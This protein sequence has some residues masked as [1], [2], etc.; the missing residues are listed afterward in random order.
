M[1]EENP[2]HR[3]CCDLGYYYDTVFDEEGTVFMAHQKT[4]CPN[5]NG[6]TLDPVL[7]Y[8]LTPVS[9]NLD[10]QDMFDLGWIDAECTHCYKTS[11][12]GRAKMM[13]AEKCPKCGVDVDF[14][15]LYSKCF[16]AADLA[17]R[18]RE[19]WSSV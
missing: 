12:F 15:H 14:W 2:Y 11:R 7:R 16:N 5:C 10:Y 13:R 17:D 4:I 19:Y 18:E 1:N 8:K 9:K 6:T 3:R